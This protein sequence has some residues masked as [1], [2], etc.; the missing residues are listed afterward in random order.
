MGR[1]NLSNESVA[2]IEK[3]GR[4]FLFVSNDAEVSKIKGERYGIFVGFEGFES[5]SEAFA[6]ANEVWKEYT[7]YA[8]MNKAYAFCELLIGHLK[9]FPE[10]LNARRT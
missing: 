8:S 2:E 6:Y 7:F 5:F 4:V 9:A 10:R 3:N 1:G